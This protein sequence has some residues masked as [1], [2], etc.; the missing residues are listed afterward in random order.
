M[1]V[2]DALKLLNH[3][4]ETGSP[5]GSFM[6]ADSYAPGF[7]KSLTE[8]AQ[9]SKPLSSRQVEV[10]VD[11]VRRYRAPMIESGLISKTEIDKMIMR[12]ECRVQPYKSTVY[13]REAR[14]LG[15]NKIGFRYKY[16]KELNKYIYQNVSDKRLEDSGMPDLPVWNSRL[17]MMI[18]P[19]TERTFNKVMLLI[20]K[21]DF[22]VDWDTAEYLA[23]CSNSRD[24]PSTVVLTDT[25][26]HLNVKDNPHLAAWVKYSIYGKIK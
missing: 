6:L 26:I 20:S 25:D 11:I 16:V 24:T 5:A 23:A 7:I 8:R 22:D 12:P 3:A 15:D 4:L 13:P 17:S 10:F 1:F 21:F 18:V 19:V 2:E 9:G 14:H